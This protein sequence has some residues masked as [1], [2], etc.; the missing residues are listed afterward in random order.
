[1]EVGGG[2]DVSHERGDWRVRVRGRCRTKQ[3]NVLR[4][5]WWRVR[6]MQMLM[7]RGFGACRAIRWEE[8]GGEGH[9]F[10][11][12]AFQVVLDIIT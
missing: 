8:R 1:M 5:I 7:I 10:V 9:A 4:Q 2:D 12:V 6:L 11:K 3:E